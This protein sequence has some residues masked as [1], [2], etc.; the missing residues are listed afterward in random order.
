MIEQ[1]REEEIITREEGYCGC[2]P[3][4]FRY[5][6]LIVTLLCLTSISSNMFTLNFTLICMAPT[7]N[8]SQEVSQ[9]HQKT[10][11]YD[12]TEKSWLMWAVAIGSLVGT[13]PFSWAYGHFGARWVFFV[14]GIISALST[15]VIP[16]AADWGIWPF[17]AARFVQGIAYAADFAAIGVLTS[18]WASLKQHAFFISVLTC[19]SPLSLT[20][21]NPIAGWMC[22]TEWLGWPIVYYSH[23][24]AGIL[25][26]VIW[27]FLYSD[28]PDMHR[29]VSIVEL[30]KIHRNKTRS[31]IEPGGTV[32]Y[33]AIC[34]NFNIIASWL[35]AFAT[36]L[37]AIFMHLYLPIYIHR[38]LNF[39]IVETGLLAAIPTFSYIPLK[40]IFGTLS[41]K[42]KGIDETTKVCIFNTIALV[43]PAL[44]YIALAFVPQTHPWWGLAL[45]ILIHML[46][47]ASGGGFYK[48]LTLSSRQ[49][50]HFVIATV[51]FFK[52]ISLFLAPALVWFF[53]DI[54]E[55]RTEWRTIFFILAFFL[56]VSAAIF[57]KAADTQPAHFT[58]VAPKRSSVSVVPRKDSRY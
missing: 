35:S 26:F 6:L 53:V 20:I 43:G 25:L 52:C 31:H 55:S 12:H 44:C 22:N 11:A 32:P 41:D 23:A 16:F 49:F 54:E 48:C 8:V 4:K 33:A 38:V 3:H 57:W 56:I 34:K 51:Q 28:F 36:L 21:T 1:V 37:S 27:V 30:E 58:K 29:R 2:L 19:Y 47:A 24:I 7:S 10:Y 13:F 17:T 9:L 50:S 18:H 39:S 45:L 15:G 40:L 14:A 5:I 46:Y 42:I